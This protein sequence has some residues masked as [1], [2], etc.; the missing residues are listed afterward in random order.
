[1]TSHI[2]HLTS[3]RKKKINKETVYYKINRKRKKDIVQTKQKKQIERNPKTIH[4]FILP[5]T[6]V[7]TVIEINIKKYHTLVSVNN[8]VC[9]NYILT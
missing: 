4:G 8:N 1:M 2:P 6:K 3:A 9:Q 5:Y 7:I